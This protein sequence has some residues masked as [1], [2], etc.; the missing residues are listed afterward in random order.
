M[1]RVL[2]GKLHWRHHAEDAVLEHQHQHCGKG[3]QSRKEGCRRLV[4]EKTY[5]HNYAYQSCKALQQLRYAFQ[6]EF[7]LVLLVVE[8]DPQHCDE[9]VQSEDRQVNNVDERQFGQ[10]AGETGTLHIRKV[11]QYKIGQSR[12]E[13]SQCGEEFSLQYY[14]DQQA[15]KSAAYKVH[16][17]KCDPPANIAHHYGKHKHYDWIEHNGKRRVVWHTE[18]LEN[19]V[20][21]VSH[22]VYKFTGYAVFRNQFV[23]QVHHCRFFCGCRRRGYK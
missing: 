8:V 2:F 13:G 23:F 5:R 20:G 9:F 3:A 11:E 16:N 21:A 14:F 6:R 15:V 18:K 12:Y 7:T 19:L 4:H 10:Y 22:V 17:L 1:Q